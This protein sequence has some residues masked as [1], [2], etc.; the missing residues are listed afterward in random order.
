M[1]RIFKALNPNKLKVEAYIEAEMGP[2]LAYEK[3]K[4][5]KRPIVMF[6]CLLLI[7]TSVLAL[8]FVFF[9]PG[10]LKNILSTV[11]DT[12]NQWADQ[13][14]FTYEEVENGDYSGEFG[15]RLL[16]GIG[17]FLLGL[18]RGLGAFLLDLLALISP[19]VVIAAMLAV[20]GGIVYFSLCVISGFGWR[21]STPEEIRESIIRG[22]DGEMRKLV[23]G[24]EGEEAALEAVSRLDDNSYIFENLVIWLDDH[25]NEADLIVVNPSGVTVM[26]VKDYS[27]TLLGDLSQPKIIQR[28]CKKN[29]KYED[30]DDADNPVQQI[31]GPA[32]KLE[33]FLARKGIS[34]AV[35]RCALFTNENVDI[36]VS[37][38]KGL[39][40]T[41]PLFLLKSPELLP[42]LHANDHQALDNEQ[43]QKVVSALRT[44][45]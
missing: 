16:S 29:G 33:A 41:C 12:L 30:K 20:A 19:V 32:K 25:K 21:A 9:G 1:A 22:M 24:L 6:V 36:Q 38:R 4:A 8:L 18:L 27:G 14:R 42:Y 3:K 35:R 17:G 10:V 11:K 45:L 26:E 37:D 34:V 44:F 2:K 13:V 39:T 31:E 28:K 40:R 5:K 7:V 15:E 43:M 23:S